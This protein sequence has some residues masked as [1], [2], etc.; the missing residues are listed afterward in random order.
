MSRALTIPTSNLDKATAALW[1]YLANN[2][3]LPVPCAVS[4]APRALEVSVQP[5]VAEYGQ[6]VPVLVALLA[7]TQN[8]DM[9]T[10]KWWLDGDGVFIVITGRVPSGVRFE[11]YKRM[12][13]DG[14]SELVSLQPGQRESVSL[15]ELHQLLAQLREREAVAA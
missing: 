13:V 12:P 3:H 5:Q 4:I 1:G 10:A 15:D 6:P 11:V 7:W 14:C 2:P 8:L 9:V